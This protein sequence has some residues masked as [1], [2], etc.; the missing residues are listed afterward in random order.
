ME[1]P[2]VG[3]DLMP[4]EVGKIFA[5]TKEERH[6]VQNYLKVR[7]DPFYYCCCFMY[8]LA[9]RRYDL[10]NI[11]KCDIDLVNK[12]VVLHSSASKNRQQD[13]VTIM[14]GFERILEEMNL[15]DVP[16]NY[17]IFG[18]GFVPSA[19]K[20]TRVNDFTE[21]FRN[22]AVNVG[23]D[24][25]KTFYGLKASG[26]SDLFTATKDPYLIQRQARHSDIRITM[27]YL[28]SLGLTVDEKIRKVNIE[29]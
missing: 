12:M 14:P 20:L 10:A 29:F 26:L 22:V 6:K 17:Y 27:T 9:L 21:Y 4:E 1:N 7:K 11:R 25:V 28:R 15:Q 13:S 8:Y 3:I 5:L 16:D 24:S 18:R 2:F 19:E 23:I